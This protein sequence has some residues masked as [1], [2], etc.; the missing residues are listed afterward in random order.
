ME[1]WHRRALFD[2]SRAR[3]A[4]ERSGVALAD[5]LERRW[6]GVDVDRSIKTVRSHSA[7]GA[8]ALLIDRRGIAPPT[9]CH[10]AGEV[11][12]RAAINRHSRCL[13]QHRIRGGEH[14]ARHAARPEK[15]MTFDIS[16]KQ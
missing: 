3:R 13:Y 11:Q 14:L 5:L 9:G 2:A 4:A 7:G 10:C 1:S 8:S 15:E 16:S 6:I 12:S